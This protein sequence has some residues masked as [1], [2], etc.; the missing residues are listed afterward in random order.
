MIE[1][2]KPAEGILKTNEWGDSKIYYI[3]CDCSDSDHAHTVEVEADDFGVHVYSYV[4]IHSKWYEKNRW[5]QIW[6]ILTKGYAEMDSTILMKEQTALN[7]AEVLNQAT[8][9]VKEF[10]RIR[11]DRQTS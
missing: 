1:P 5:K 7:Y 6:Q 9:D 11:N 2:Q 8:H 4:K 10:K 3:V